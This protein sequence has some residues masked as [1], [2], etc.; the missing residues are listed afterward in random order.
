MVTRISVVGIG[1]GND[2]ITV[3]TGGLGAAHH[4]TDGEGVGTIGPHH[5]TVVIPVSGN[6]QC[7]GASFPVEPTIGIEVIADG[8]GPRCFVLELVL[9]VK[10]QVTGAG[11]VSGIECQSTIFILQGNAAA[12]G[13]VVAGE[14]ESTYTLLD[15]GTT[16]A[17]VARDFRSDG[18]TGGEVGIEHHVARSADPADGFII[19]DFK[20]ARGIDGHNTGVFNGRAIADFQRAIVDCPV[21][22]VRGGGAV[23]V[24]SG[25]G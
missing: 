5:R 11:S 13:G 17:D 1:Q 19:V 16:A 18:V 9:V 10:S 23:E 7:L 21:V 8:G 22:V 6:L 24:D 3:E 12:E 4:A 14:G 2:S 20:G 15:Q 25:Q